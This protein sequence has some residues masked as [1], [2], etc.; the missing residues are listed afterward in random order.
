MSST[1][2]LLKIFF[3]LGKF[4]FPSSVDNISKSFQVECLMTALSKRQ[5]WLGD[6]RQ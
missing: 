5:R 2:F 3:G 6:C 1:R 4:I